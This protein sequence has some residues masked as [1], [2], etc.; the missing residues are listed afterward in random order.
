MWSPKR[1]C[2]RG[3]CKELATESWRGPIMKSPNGCGFLISQLPLGVLGNLYINHPGF[4]RIN[5][6][7]GEFYEKETKC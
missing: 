5:L 7:K 2:P 3:F 1:A 4:D 6:R